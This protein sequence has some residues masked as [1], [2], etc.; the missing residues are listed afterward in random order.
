MS[1]EDTTFVGLL[2][3]DTD[4]DG[5]IDDWNRDG[6]KDAGLDIDNTSRSDARR[7]DERV[8]STAGRGESE[9]QAETNDDADLNIPGTK[10]QR[11]L[12]APSTGLI[13]WTRQSGLTDRLF[14]FLD[15]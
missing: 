1:V 2:F 15:T 3:G 4:F 12:P 5:V 8:N 13:A 14:N 7:T 11:Q 9:P 6:V 10:L